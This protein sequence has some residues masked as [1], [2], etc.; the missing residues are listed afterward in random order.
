M[1]SRFHLDPAGWF[2]PGHQSEHLKLVADAVVER[3]PA[4]DPLRK[5]EAHLGP[6]DRP[7]RR[8]A[9]G[10]HLVRS[11]AGGRKAADLPALLHP[12][13]G[14]DQ[15]DLR[16]A[17]RPSTCPPTGRPRPAS[18]RRTVYAGIARVRASEKG[19]SRFG[20]ISATVKQAVESTPGLVPDAEGWAVLSIPIE[21]VGWAS[22][23][24]DPHRR[25][26]RGAG[27]ARAQ[28]PRGRGSA[29]DGGVLRRRGVPIWPPGDQTGKS[30]DNFC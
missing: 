25:R 24:D 7:A 2:Q 28:G 11:G 23:R 19:R 5:L 21:E 16:A 27:A 17:G 1:S 30:L 12:R 18:S 29:E 14:G 4:G 15:P 22:R 26:D 20:S 10:R 13:A 6:G 3:A 8:R 9:Q